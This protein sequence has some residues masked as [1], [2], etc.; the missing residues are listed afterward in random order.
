MNLLSRLTRWL[1]VR[2]SPNPAVGGGRVNAPASDPA[3]IQD[4][5]FYALPLSMP[6][7]FEEE[8]RRDG[9]YEEYLREASVRDT[10][11]FQFD[12]PQR[13]TNDLP[14]PV[15]T[16]DPLRELNWT[17]RRFVLSHTHSAIQRNPLAKRGVRLV[18]DFVV[19][20]DGFTLTCQNQ[21]VQQVLEAFINHPDNDIRTYER[22][23]IPDLLADGELIGRWF[24]GEDGVLVFV[25]QRPWELMWITTDPGFF[26]RKISYHFQRYLTRGDDPTGAQA[27]EIEDVKADEI[28]FCAINHHA[29]ELRGRPEL[30]DILPWLKSYKDWLENR[31]RQNHWRST[32]VWWVSIA[33]SVP[34]ILAAKATQYMR[35]P[36]PGSVVVTSDQEK[37]QPL[38]N[39]VGAGDA[40]DDG[41]QIKLMTAVGF[42]LPEYMLSDGY[43]VNLASA[44]KQ[45]LPALTT[46][47]G[48]QHILVRQ[49]WTPM[50]K[51]VLQEAIDNGQLP[52]EVEMQ[53]A[54]GDPVLEDPPPE[55]MAQAA[56][57]KMAQQRAAAALPF[58][59]KED[60]EEPPESPEPAE[61]VRTPVKMPPRKP[62]KVRTL[63]AF[64]VSY[65]PL[66]ED[67]MLTIAQ[68]MQIAKTQEVVSKETFADKLGLDYS[69][70]RKRMSRE[71]AEEQ[72]DMAAGLKTPPPGFTPDGYN[73]HLPSD[74][75]PNEPS[76]QDVAQAIADIG[77]RYAKAVS[78]ATKAPD[79]STRVK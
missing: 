23:V 1:E 3:S 57:A 38:T 19:G 75:P 47:G 30:Y 49:W 77:G 52:E 53:D 69:I 2:L 54:D 43:N 59:P 20:D 63:D 28:Q 29:Y 51:R 8:L 33:T 60:A 61:D 13:G 5:A 40:S 15:F 36:T 66:S 26:K 24:T 42:G 46:F 16:D 35:P 56:Q 37:W 10:Y 64:D 73:D 39:P 34:A 41:R 67:A 44:N 45:Q 6:G 7:Y 76:P 21:D 72:T 78:Q 68:A 12:T 79:N 74:E 17:T 48:Y 27:T 32:L 70:E 18:G 58:M 50:F 55:V 25:P 4:G 31:A 71:S 22:Q 65:P 11:R 9:K 14:I 62:K